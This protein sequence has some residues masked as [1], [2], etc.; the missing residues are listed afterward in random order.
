MVLI[1]NPDLDWPDW[2]LPGAQAYGIYEHN[3]YVACPYCKGSTKILAADGRLV[4]CECGDGRIMQKEWRVF[5]PVF[6]LLTM[7]GT[8]TYQGSQ[9]DVH[10]QVSKAGMTVSNTKDRCFQTGVDAAAEC[11]R[12]NQ[13]ARV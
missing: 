9:I 2:L 13:K 4:R 3:L 1:E 11:T 7:H 10:F 12:R 8:G 6:V 5:G